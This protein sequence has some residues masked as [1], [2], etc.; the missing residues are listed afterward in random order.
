VHGNYENYAC[1]FEY[2]VLVNCALKLPRGQRA[3]LVHEVASVFFNPKVK[4]AEVRSFILC[5]FCSEH[6]QYFGLE[7]RGPLH[8]CLLFVIKFC[9]IVGTKQYII[10]QHFSKH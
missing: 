6:I 9:F 8:A 4:V 3:L 7:Y 2:M 10:T 5:S 1:M